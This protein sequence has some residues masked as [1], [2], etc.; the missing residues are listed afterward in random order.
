VIRK[1]AQR[2]VLRSK[3]RGKNLGRPYKSK[4]AALK[5]ERQVQFFKHDK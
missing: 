1:T 4:E 3:K 2:Y 5:R